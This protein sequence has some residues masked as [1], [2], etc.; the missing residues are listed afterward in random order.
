M[1]HLY[2]NLSLPPNPLLFKQ[3][4]L[5]L[6]PISLNYHPF[7]LVQ[8]QQGDATDTILTI[9]FVKYRFFPIK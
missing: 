8:I 4:I 6:I 7:V 5:G 3:I 9:E 1:V 2:D